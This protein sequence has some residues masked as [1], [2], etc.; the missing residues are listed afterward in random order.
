MEVMMMVVKVVYRGGGGGG[1]VREGYGC[2]VRDGGG[3]SCGG[4]SD[5]FYILVYF[6]DIAH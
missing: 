6:R 4:V 1:G 5:S 3:V 2:G